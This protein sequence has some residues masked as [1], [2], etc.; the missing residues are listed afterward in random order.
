MSEPQPQTVL[1]YFLHWERAQPEKVFL[2]QPYPDGR[3]VDYTW[4]QAGDQA[5][6]M[7]AYLRSLPLE[8][9][10]RIA[11][12]G[13]NSAHW[14]IADLAI[15]MSGHVSVP[16]YPTMGAAQVRYVLE[17][18]GSQLLLLG[19]LDGTVDNWPRIETGL[20]VGLPLFGLPLSP[21][22]DIPQWD[23]V[24]ARHAPLAVVHHGQPDELCSILYTSGSTGMPKGVMHGYA[25]MLANCPAMDQVVGGGSP[26]DRI[27]SYLPLAHVAERAF[28]FTLVCMGGHVFFSNSLSTFAADLQRARPTFFFSVPRLWIKFQQ[29]VNAKLPPARQRLLFA[30]P[31]VSKLVKRKI[32]R[33]LG[34]D[35]A[36]ICF[37]GSAPLP[38]EI[39]SWYRNLGLEMLDGYGM[40]ETYITH[41]SRPGQVRIGYV[42]QAVSGVR[43]RIASDG[44]VLVRTPSQMLGYYK[45]PALTAQSTLADG[46]FRTGD[47]G[48][49]DEVGRLRITGRTKDLF[50]TEGGKYV[51]P[52]PIENLLGAHPRLEGACVTGPDHPH[53]FAL[54]M[55]S[56]DSLQALDEKSLT[57]EQLDSELDAL[58]QRVN[59][60]LE[61]HEKLSF[62]VV[63]RD[64]WT[65]ENG[66]LTPTLKIKRDALESRYLPHARTWLAASRSVVWE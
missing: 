16:L 33:Q 7:A 48:E 31:V 6:R 13:R 17:H 5:R 12:L 1:A 55:L 32:L 38:S 9:G 42:G 60:S 54:L 40:T 53:P 29:A 26:A 30:L 34:L 19:K 66:L 21:R 22:H 4:A 56:A 65:V 15:M 62:A 14:I 25:G 50:K 46:F 36:R 24:I 64:P 27:V 3:V 39:V 10:S 23:D 20:P 52:A 63:T 43:T 59:S 51:A 8:P 41:C 61:K 28:V 49:I 35:H 2:T 18:S 44:E 57:R 45:D 11:L 37:T 47:R 58:L